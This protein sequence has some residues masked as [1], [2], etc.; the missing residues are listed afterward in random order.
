[1][2]RW[3]RWAM[4]FGICG[5]L[6]IFTGCSSPQ[7]ASTRAFQFETDTFA[8]ANEIENAYGYDEKGEWCKRPV[9]PEPTYSRHCFV[10][11]RSAR[12]FFQ[13][14]RFEPDLPEVSEADYRKL[15]RKVVGMSPR[16]DLPAQIV[17]PGYANLREFS[18]E[19][20]PLLKE[21]CGSLWQS[22]FQRG[23][24]RMVFPFTGR[25]RERMAGQLMEAVQAQRPPVVHLVRFPGL[26]INHAVVIYDARETE[27]E[28]RFA[29]YDPNSPESPTR[30]AFDRK[31]RTFE[32][33]R[34]K[35]FEGG[36]VQ[37]YEV[38]RGCY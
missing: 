18:A 37:A 9:K 3:H 10:V 4:T 21:E 17:I 11:A 8:Y 30:L 1:M 35:S 14:A 23:H 38:Y 19:H 15:V 33:P 13:H 16:K 32:F 7:V 2:A 22:Y 34:N 6:V 25:Q 28:I 26:E 27:D 20:E 31:K 5:L 36:L 24:W 12:Q 29:V